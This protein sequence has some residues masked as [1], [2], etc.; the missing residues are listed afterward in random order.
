MDR[1]W[2]QEA[3]DAKPYSSYTEEEFYRALERWKTGAKPEIFVFFKRVDAAPE[4]DPGPQLK[5]VMDFRKQLEET[6]QVLYHYFDGDQSFIAEVDRHLRAY[7]KGELP[8]TDMQQGI[9]ILPVSA[10]E[11]V[12]RAKSIAIQKSEEAEKAHNVER[13]SQLKI[14]EMQL[15]NAEDAAKLSKE[16]KVE[17]ARQRFSELVVESENLRILHLSYEFYYRT[18]DLDSA[19]L[20]ME[21]WLNLSSAE[22]KSSDTAA[23]LGNL[24]ILYLTQGELGHVEEIYK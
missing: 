11:E 23:A 5:K 12:E 24:G 10:V 4:A 3:P 17:F 6:R 14:E 2:G 13:A 19:F 18:G 21:K 9:V 20:V 22:E 15:Q 7:A 16:G 1:R 8:K